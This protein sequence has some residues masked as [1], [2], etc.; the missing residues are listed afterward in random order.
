[1]S[2]AESRDVTS[3][4]HDEL[5]MRIFSEAAVPNPL[6][7]SISIVTKWPVKA[8]ATM[9]LTKH[10]SRLSACEPPETALEAALTTTARHARTDIF[11]ALLD[12]YDAGHPLLQRP[13]GSTG[14]GTASTASTA[15]A[16]ERLSFKSM[17]YLAA[18]NGAVDV[19]QVMLDRRLCPLEEIGLAAAY[20]DYRQIVEK[21]DVHALPD[22]QNLLL[23]AV[24]RGCMRLCEELVARGLVDTDRGKQLLRWCVI[25]RCATRWLVELL[26]IMAMRIADINGNDALIV[27]AQRVDIEVCHHLIKRTQIRDET[28]RKAYHMLNKPLAQLSRVTTEIR[29]I[30]V[31]RNNAIDA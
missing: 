24:S 20:F 17:V 30:M 8:K 23:V 7:R 15:V 16:A 6:T 10:M 27:A 28:M 22:P 9:L 26:N 19:M 5:W 29:D 13:I 4:L 21:I 25:K 18:E 12:M 11:V 31:R 2:A 1:M 3:H 14:T